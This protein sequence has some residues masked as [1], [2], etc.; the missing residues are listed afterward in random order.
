MQFVVLEKIASANLFQIGREKSFDY[1]LIIY[2]GQILSRFGILCYKW[3]QRAT[4]NLLDKKSAVDLSVK[5][6][7]LSPNHE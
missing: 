3:R 2:K 7:S 6:H 4:S 5:I 1:L